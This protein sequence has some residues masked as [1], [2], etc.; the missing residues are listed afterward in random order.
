MSYTFASIRLA[1][2]GIGFLSML[3]AARGDLVI[4]GFGDII[5]DRMVM[6]G[7]SMEVDFGVA[8]NG[9]VNVPNQ[10][11]AFNVG[12]RFVPTAG[13]VGGLTAG[14]VSPSDENSVF[15]AFNP[16]PFISFP[17]ADV[18]TVNGNNQAFENVSIT[19]PRSLF[20]LTFTSPM[21]DALGQFQVFGVPEFTSYFTTTEFDGFRFGNVPDGADVLL[22]TVTVTSTAV[23][24]PT[25]LLGV[26]LVTAGIAYRMRRRSTAHD[27]TT[28]KN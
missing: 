21:N 1:A 7:E 22:G 11:N 25:S 13:A 17:A 15:P 5:W 23:P 8:A 20:A 19:Q 12:L 24:E 9:D 10:L 4:E 26:A 16:P 28:A 3:S 18:P 2:F 14:T 6:P 27:K